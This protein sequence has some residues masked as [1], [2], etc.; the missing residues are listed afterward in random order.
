[1]SVLGADD[2]GN[3]LSALMKNEHIGSEYMVHSADR[4]TTNKIRI[5]SRNQQMMRLD[6]EITSYLSP[7]DENLL[8]DSFKPL[9]P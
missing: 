2:D 4:L 1:M 9:S 3:Q 6:A 8:L 7:G 5:I